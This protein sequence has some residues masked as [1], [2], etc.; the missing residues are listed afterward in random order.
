MELCFITLFFEYVTYM[1]YHEYSMMPQSSDRFVRIILTIEIKI[2][3]SRWQIMIK[4]TSIT[5][6]IIITDSY[7]ITTWFEWSYC[8]L[9]DSQIA[10]VSTN[11]TIRHIHPHHYFHHSLP[12]HNQFH[13][14]LF[15]LLSWLLILIIIFYFLNTNL[16]FESS[17]KMK[18]IS[19]II[20]S[21]SHHAA[22]WINEEQNKKQI[23][24]MWDNYGQ[25]KLSYYCYF[26][27]VC[28]PLQDSSHLIAFN[29][30]YEIIYWPRHAN[31][32]K[33]CPNRNKL[34]AASLLCNAFVCL[35]IAYWVQIHLAINHRRLKPFM[36]YL[37]YMAAR[38]RWTQFV[39]LTTH[40]HALKCASY[41]CKQREALEGE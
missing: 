35:E 2:N 36:R 41:E 34:L 8:Q 9:S 3:E 7:I 32:I 26:I 1:Y 29:H 13:S 33:Y 4:K 5:I 25:I 6:R 24:V 31:N 37:E 30:Q 17:N 21:T 27:T 19:C 18:S 15:S 39:E 22:I 40:T 20:I 16:N 38:W 23:I 11:K 10:C 28:W 14:Y 12:S